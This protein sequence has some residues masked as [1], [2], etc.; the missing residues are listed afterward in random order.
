MNKTKKICC[1]LDQDKW[2]GVKGVGER[3]QEGSSESRPEEVR[4]RA[5]KTSGQRFRQ[6]GQRC[7]GLLWTWNLLIFTLFRATSC[8]PLLLPPW[9]SLHTW[10]GWLF[11]IKVRSHHFPA[12]NPPGAPTTL[13]TSAKVLPMV[14]R[15]L[16]S[17]ALSPLSLAHSFPASLPWCCFWTTPSKLQPHS[18]HPQPL[19]GC[20]SWLPSLASWLHADAT[21]SGGPPWLTCP[22]KCPLSSVP[23]LCFIC[24]H[25]I[26]H[27]LPSFY[28]FIIIAIM[29]QMFTMCWTVF[30]QPRNNSY[31]P[32]LLENGVIT[33]YLL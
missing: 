13:R 17:P 23:C 25:N 14:L 10:L 28:I 27:S 20:P 31:S 12:P 4:E 26:Y 19:P 33:N 2:E 1:I 9:P 29:D 16:P 11:K 21:F 32:K 5:R 6:R 15:Y 24:L 18:L 7:E 22:S 3:G 8:L 30:K